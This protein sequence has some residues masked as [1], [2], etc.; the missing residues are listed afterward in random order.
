MAIRIDGKALAAKVKGEV[1]KDAE[2]LRAEGIIPCLTVVLVG[3]DPGS[4]IYVRNKKKACEENGIA[5]RSFELPADTS[6]EQIL[7]LVAELNAD[8]TVDGILIQQPLPKHLDPLKLMEAVD[9][10]KD[11]D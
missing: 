6:E 9:P 10:K 5:S 8:P 2:L 11:V 7:G 3:E 1:A 4:Q